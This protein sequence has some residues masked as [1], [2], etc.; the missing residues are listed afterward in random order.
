MLSYLLCVLQEWWVYLIIIDVCNDH[1]ALREINA[2]LVALETNHPDK[3]QTF[4]LPGETYEGRDI[5]V[6]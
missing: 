4:N 2:H 5:K 1:C 6:S 3:A